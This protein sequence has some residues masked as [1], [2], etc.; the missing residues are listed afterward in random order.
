MK[1]SRTHRVRAS[2]RST[3]IPVAFTPDALWMIEPRMASGAAS[4]STGKVLP[5]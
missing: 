3:L 1:A 5:T 2:N 4:A